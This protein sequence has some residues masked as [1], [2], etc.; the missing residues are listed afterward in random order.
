MGRAIFRQDI[1]KQ[2][3]DQLVF[4]PSRQ[5]IV[6]ATPDGNW[7]LFY[8][9]DGAKR[10][11][12]R[13]PMKGGRAELLYEVSGVMGL[14]CSRVGPCIVSERHDGAVVVSEL[15]AVKG[16]KG[17][18][19]YRDAGVSFAGPDVSPDAKWLA[20]PSGTKIILRSFAT[21]EVVR[22]IP[23]RGATNA[24]NLVNLDYAADGK[25]FFAGQTTPTESRQLYID[26]SGK[27]SVL[28]RQAGKSTVWG[29]P[30]PDGRYLAMMVYTDDSNVYTL[31]DF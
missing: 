4:G 6:R 12:M 15:D 18:E 19:I 8:G 31:D 2:T 25:G 10:G 20:T 29:V 28:W 7:T 21:G 23:V 24:M 22:E 9:R 1:H 16:T 3:A 30:S 26:L 13:A 27:A 14:R 17:R 5:I 11:L